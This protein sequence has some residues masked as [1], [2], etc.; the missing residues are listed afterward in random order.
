METQPGQG[1]T[2]VMRL[3][4][5]MPEGTEAEDEASRTG[6]AAP[7]R[8]RDLVLVVDD[9]PAQRDLMSRFLHRQGFEVRTAADGEAGLQQARLLK[10]RAILLDVM[11]PRMDGWSV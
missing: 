4:A 8:E 2:F 6:D 11:M 5:I 1:S 9:D 3:P 7:Q 10:P